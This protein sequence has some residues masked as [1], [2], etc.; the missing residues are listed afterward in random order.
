MALSMRITVYGLFVSGFTHLSATIVAMS[1]NICS[2]C[3]CRSLSDTCS[4][5]FD[6]IW[7]VSNSKK[8]V[9]K[10]HGCDQG[11]KSL[12]N[13]LNLTIAWMVWSDMKWRKKII[14]LIIYVITTDSTER[15]QNKNPPQKNY[16]KRSADLLEF[17]T[18]PQFVYYQE[19]LRNQI[20]S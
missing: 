10:C 18:S 6:K 7:T 15:F 12:V 17:A 4:S 2:S 1:L 14:V 11:V 5:P 20:C 3:V 16:K 8:S 13:V 9:N 19:G